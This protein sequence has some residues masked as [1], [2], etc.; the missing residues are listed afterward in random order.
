METTCRGQGRSALGKISHWQLTASKCPAKLQLGIAYALCVCVHQY[1]LWMLNLSGTAKPGLPHWFEDAVLGFQAVDGQ[2]NAESEYFSV[3]IWETAALEK[4][5]EIIWN[6]IY[7]WR[8]YTSFGWSSKPPRIITKFPG[9]AIT[10]IT[11][12]DPC[13]H[14][15]PPFQTRYWRRLP[16]SWNP[17]WPCCVAEWWILDPSMWRLWFWP[18]TLRMM[19]SEGE[20]LGQ[21]DILI[22]YIYICVCVCIHIQIHI[23]TILDGY[24]PST[25][26]LE[27]IW[28]LRSRGFWNSG[29]AVDHPTPISASNLYAGHCGL[30][31]SMD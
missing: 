19:R 1:H 22:Y 4:G 7:V 3:I 30:L 23:C 28:C 29:R 21:S 25:P 9:W 16:W 2:E 10:A 13:T 27:Q 31:V 6:H 17:W 24:V 8:L 11:C 18:A 15:T 5:H 26:S 14:C 20:K 12:R